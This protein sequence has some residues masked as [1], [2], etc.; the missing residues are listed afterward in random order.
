MSKFDEFLANQSSEGVV[1]SEGSFTLATEKAL[2][3]MSEFALA[4]SEDWVLKVVQAAVIAEANELAFRIRR[5]TIQ[6]DVHSDGD[7][8]LDDLELRLLNPDSAEQACWAEIF[9]ALRSILSS[10]TYV[11]ANAEGNW[12]TWDGKGFD[13]GRE[14]NALPPGSRL[15]IMARKTSEN[16]VEYAKDQVARAREVAAY[17]SVLEERASYAPLKL[18]IDGRVL[19]TKERLAFRDTIMRESSDKKG[20]IALLWAHIQPGKSIG[21]APAPWRPFKDRLLSRSYFLASPAVARKRGD[22]YFALRYNF[23]EWGEK[24]IGSDVPK[25]KRRSL[26]GRFSLLFTRWGVIA[27]RKSFKSV[28]EGELVTSADQESTDL[29]GLQIDMNSPLLREASSYLSRL[30]EPVEQLLGSLEA[31]RSGLNVELPQLKDL[32]YISGGIGGGFAVPA[33]FTGLA[34]VPALKAGLVIGSIVAPF[35]STVERMSGTQRQLL[36]KQ[37]RDFI[38]EMNGLTAKWRNQ[39]SA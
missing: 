36:T 14:K 7:W 9:I 22:R 34:F 18:T 38:P 15:R 29:T 32:A 24:Q 12:L 10:H 37:V 13:S 26:E 5:D 11:I 3:K 2:K 20:T 6:V 27:G 8:D 1:E 23:L 39:D 19:S 25:W 16:L 31:H 17:Q 33:F 35:L 30:K 21:L 4:S 28:L